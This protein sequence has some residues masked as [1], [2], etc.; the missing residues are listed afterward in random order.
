MKIAVDKNSYK[1]AK[2]D[3]NKYIYLY[4]YLKVLHPLTKHLH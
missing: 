3:G 1:V 4:D 2:D